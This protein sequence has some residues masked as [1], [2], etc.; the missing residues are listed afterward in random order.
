MRHCDPKTLRMRKENGRTFNLYQIS[1][2]NGM[3]RRE[4]KARQK[5]E[6]ERENERERRRITYYQHFLKIYNEKHGEKGDM[7]Q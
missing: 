2:D 5:D 1:L 3:K 6:R 4:R 7:R